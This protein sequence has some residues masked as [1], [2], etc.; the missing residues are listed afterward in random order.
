MNQPEKSEKKSKKTP[1]KNKTMDWIIRGTV[2]GVLGVLLIVALLDFTAKQSAQGTADAWR[3]ALKAKDEHADLFKSEFDKVPVKG[4][5]TVTTTQSATRSITANS[6]ST[7][8]WRGTF[9]TY[10]VK[11]SFGMGN[12]PTVESI[13]G[14]GEVQ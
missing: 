1:A 9:R 3:A 11:V 6:V 13:D 12:D 7:Y 14:P 5:P 2:F 8:V 4:S 10:T